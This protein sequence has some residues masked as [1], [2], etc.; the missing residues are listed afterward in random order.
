MKKEFV[1]LWIN[2]GKLLEKSFLTSVKKYIYIFFLKSRPHNNSLT[3]TTVAQTG[4]ANP[5]VRNKRKK[6]NWVFFFSPQRNI[7][8]KKWMNTQVFFGYL[9]KVQEVVF[10]CGEKESQI[11]IDQHRLM[12]NH[13]II[14][15]VWPDKWL[16][17]LLS[18]LVGRRKW[19]CSI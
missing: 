3:K 17:S 5:L 15:T 1:S 10:L 8:C 4:E 9:N 7:D 12:K 19:L 18:P 11:S 2:V 6:N 13:P 16:S 14:P